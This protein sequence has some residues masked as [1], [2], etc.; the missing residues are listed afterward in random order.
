MI[1]FYTFLIMYTG[2]YIIINQALKRNSLL[3]LRAMEVTPSI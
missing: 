3:N 2:K 1:L